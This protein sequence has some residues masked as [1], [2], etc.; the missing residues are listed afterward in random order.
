MQTQLQFPWGSSPPPD[1]QRVEDSCR[2]ATDR[3][4]AHNA[5]QLRAACAA[6]SATDISACLPNLPDPERPP[7]FPPLRAAVESGVFGR[8]E[9]GPIEPDDEDVASLTVEHGREMIGLL[10]DLA[11]VEHG[12]RTG[13][14]PRSG[15]VPRKPETRTRLAERLR[16]ERTLRQEAYADALT[17]YAEAFGDDA[18]A[19]LDAWVRSVVT[20]GE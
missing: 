19:A 12:L 10:A 17:V 3:H 13:Q 15:K 1:F 6:A 8:T 2:D 16:A 14:D 7:V 9:A 11:A 5:A 20:R 18:S 4:D